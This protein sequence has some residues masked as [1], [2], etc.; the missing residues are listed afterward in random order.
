M[1]VVGLLG[2]NGYWVKMGIAMGQ[3]GSFDP[4]L[5]RESCIDH[6]KTLPGQ[7]FFKQFPNLVK[8]RACA[9]WCGDLKKTVCVANNYLRVDSTNQ[10]IS[11]KSA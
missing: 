2:Q 8:S 4:L 9:P 1:C 6:N 7:A 10:A 5:I 11:L 3:N